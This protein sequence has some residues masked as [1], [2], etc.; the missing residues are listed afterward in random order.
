MA[1]LSVKQ[2]E[3]SYV[4]GAMV[5]KGL[6]T[7]VH[8]GEFIVIIGPS[9]SGKSTFVRCINKIVDISDGDMIFDG[10]AVKGLSGKKLR[11]IR[12][13]IGMIFQHYNLI[14]RT[15]VI[16]NV[17]HGRLGHVS[18]FKSALG[19]YSAEEKREAYN[20]LKTV[21]LADHIHKRAGE[22]SGGQMQ[23]V[24]ICRAM[25]QNPKLLLADEPIASLDPKSAEQVMELIHAM[26]KE[27][28][29]T[30]IMNLH[31]VEFAKKYASRI[32]G[33]KNGEIVYDGAPENLSESIISSIYEGKEDEMTLPEQAQ[34][35]MFKL[36]GTAGWE[37]Q[38]Q[39]A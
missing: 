34:T 10:T 15:N 38:T 16:K 11:R 4:K 20:L 18:S 33:L 21:G 30:C 17:L 39:T 12:S 9:G 5:L 32:I 14:G 1:L 25:M 23:R 19:L 31:Q 27:R 36:G 29:L 7:D 35:D 28:K 13:Q 37:R 26:V 8:E 3:K 2:L 6:N 22:L 24:G